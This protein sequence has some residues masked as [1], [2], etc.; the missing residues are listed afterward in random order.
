MYEKSFRPSN[1]H[2]HDIPNIQKHFR[3]DLIFPTCGRENRPAYTCDRFGKVIPSCQTRCTT[4]VRS[5]R[6]NP[7]LSYQTCFW[8]V[9]RGA[10]DLITIYLELYKTPVDTQGRAPVAVS[11]SALIVCNRRR[12]CLRHVIHVSHVPHVPL[13]QPYKQYKPWSQLEFQQCT[14]PSRWECPV[15]HVVR[16]RQLLRKFVGTR[17]PVRPRGVRRLD[18][19]HVPVER[20][21]IRHAES[22]RSP[23]HIHGEGRLIK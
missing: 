18:A 6:G 17:L 23:R 10:Y 15:P 7:Y 3:N 13:H 12:W 5:F 14:R 9:R 2:N 19:P 4:C 22:Q 20:R 21:E 1:I 11:L 16:Q 8:S